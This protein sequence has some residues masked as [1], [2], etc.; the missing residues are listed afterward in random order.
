[1]AHSSIV[2]LD[3]GVSRI[4]VHNVTELV[5]FWLFFKLVPG[6]LVVV[7]LAEAEEMS[8]RLGILFSVRISQN[9]IDYI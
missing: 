2:A 7:S 6:L 4:A 3:D 8:L 5:E 9:I 1:V